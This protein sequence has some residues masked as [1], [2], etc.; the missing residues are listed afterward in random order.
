MASG[1]YRFTKKNPAPKESMTPA[2]S[3]IIIA[4]EVNAELVPVKLFL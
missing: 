3:A 2:K 4:K 1:S